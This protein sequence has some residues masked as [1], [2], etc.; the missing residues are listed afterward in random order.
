MS[1]EIELTA[2]LHE[3]DR[4]RIDALIS[5]LHELNM[6]ATH[7]PQGSK[8]AAPW[9][10]DAPDLSPAQAPE[11]PEAEQPEAE[12]T[13]EPEPPAQQYGL[14]DVQKKVVELSAAGKK[15]QV[16]EIVKAYAERVSLI[17]EDKLDEVMGKL[18]TLEG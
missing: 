14:A 16:R 2:S 12:A 1:N 3:E 15:E 4:A 7:V 17:P 6:H 13:P 11:E 10:K 8:P 18:L 9:E 5:E